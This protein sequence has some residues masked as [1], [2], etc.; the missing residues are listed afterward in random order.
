VKR[1]SN[2]YSKDRT[3]NKY[4]SWTTYNCLQNGSSYVIMSIK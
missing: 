1:I 3:D 2:V 4:S